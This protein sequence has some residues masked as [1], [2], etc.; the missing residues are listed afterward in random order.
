MKALSFFFFY[1]QNQTLT[2]QPLS[3]S[4]STLSIQCQ[5]SLDLDEN[6]SKII[7]LKHSLNLNLDPY[8]YEM[9]NSHKDQSIELQGNAH[10]LVTIDTNHFFTIFGRIQRRISEQDFTF[11]WVNLQEK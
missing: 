4:I 11:G 2:N 6:T 5:N 8:I 9:Q 3:I 7:R 1:H 10:K